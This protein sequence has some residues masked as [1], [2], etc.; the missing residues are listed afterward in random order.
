MPVSTSARRVPR[1]WKGGSLQTH[2]DSTST[3]TGVAYDLGGHA[4]ANFAASAVGASTA[5]RMDLQGSI[6]GTNWVN[7]TTGIGASATPTATRSTKSTPFQ[8]VRNKVTAGTTSTSVLVNAYVSVNEAG[9]ADESTNA[10]DAVNLSQVG[11]T[12][13]KQGPGTS[14]G[15]VLRTVTGVTALTAAAP[16]TDKQV[17]STGAVTLAAASASRRR[18]IIQNNST[19]GHLRFTFG[20]AVASTGVPPTAVKGLRLGPLDTYIEE[21]DQVHQGIVKGIRQSTGTALKIGVLAS[22]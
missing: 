1:T 14:T 9:V 17:T 8:F 19:A 4:A 11:G 12:T 20:A 15:N 18:L 22:S 16:S 2:R 3:G 21:G 6:D 13:V 7:L 10:N 5:W